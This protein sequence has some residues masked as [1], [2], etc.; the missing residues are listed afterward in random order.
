MAEFCLD[1]WNR[2]MDSNDP[3]GKYII[4]RELDLCEECGELKPVIIRIKWRYVAA[5]WFSEQ[6][7]YFVK[8]TRK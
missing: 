7:N 6:I 2:I 4:S 8:G 3:P 5:E 1:C